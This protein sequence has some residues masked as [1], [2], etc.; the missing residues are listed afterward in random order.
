MLSA[1]LYEDRIVLI[2]SEAIDFHKT[3]Y[4]HELLKPYAS[5]RLTFLTGFAQ[6]EN[7]LLA[8]KNLRNIGI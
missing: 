3:K 4:L 8:A 1:K 7:F 6:D 5:D 2:E